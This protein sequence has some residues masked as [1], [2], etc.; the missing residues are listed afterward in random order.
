MAVGK[1]PTASLARETARGASGIPRITA[2]AGPGAGALLV[3]TQTLASAG[4]HATNDLVIDDPSVSGAHLEL[5]RRVG[6]VRIRDVGSTNGTWLG[7][8]R[9]VDVELAP[10]AEITIG[11]TTLR[12]DSAGDARAVDPSPRES[13]GGLV[14]RS[15]AMRELF[16]TLE[17]IASTELS[18]VIH[19]ETGTGKEEVARAVHA[20]SK[21]RDRPL[22][23]I[24]ATSLPETLAESL[25]FGHERGAFTG[26]TE[27]REGFF[28]AANGGTVFIDEVGELSGA[29]QA[30]FLRVL[31]RHEIVRVGGHQPV[32]V[33]VRIV[34]ATHRDLRNE[35]DGRRFRDDLY[36][37]LAQIRVRLPPLRDRLEDLDILCQRL[38]EGIA[39]GDTRRVAV[40]PEALAHLATLSWPGNVRELRNVLARAVALMSGDVVR[41]SDVAGEGDGF[42][43]TREERTVLDVAGLF[44]EAK[45][46]AIE[47]FE[48]AYLAALMRRTEGNLSRASRES[49]VVRHHLR[50]LLRK[51]GLYHEGDPNDADPGTRH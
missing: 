14:G 46:R 33:D 38:L 40:D 24:D 37:R 22:V 5:S 11:R 27:R 35:I 34:A 12:F 20:S 19:G 15:I 36:F 9:V 3:M 29:L 45:Q 41:R 49:G 2:T 44:A 48:S 8:H 51:R 50:E 30:K 10:G 39:E 42:R 47:R 25:L 23:V 4:R 18:I 17:R 16:A 7:P 32:K 1:G 31:E 13:F 6:G 26:A 43:G 21:R 28:E